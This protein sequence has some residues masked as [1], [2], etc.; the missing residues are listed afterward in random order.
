MSADRSARFQ[1]LL[2]IL[3][4][5]H[6]IMSAAEI[7]EWDQETY[8][9]E[10]ANEARARQVATLRQSAHARFI[11]D[12]TG[13]L[14]EQLSGGDYDPL[15]F[16]GS[17]VR[18]AHRDYLRAR[19]VPASLVGR[20]A[21][22]TSH[23]KV[24][25]RQAREE[26]DW[27]QFAAYLDGILDLCREKIDALGYEECPYDALLDE[28]EPEMRTSQ[29]QQLCE[30]LRP[31]L[32]ELV[33]AIQEAEQPETGFLR[34]RFSLKRQWA[35]GAEV[36]RTIGYDFSRGRQDLSTHPF[37]TAFST[38]DVRI[39]TRLDERWLCSGLFSSL[40]E[41]GHGMYEQG[42]DPDLEGTLL[43]QGTS[44]G[45]HESQSRL[46]ENQIGRSLPFWKYFFPILRRRFN[47]Q[48]NGVELRDFYDAINRVRPSLIR[49]EADEV[50]YNLHIMLRFEIELGLMDG[51]LSVNDVPEVW[52]DRMHTYLGIIPDTD[53]NGCLQDIHWALGAIGYFPTYMLGNLMAAQIFACAAEALPRLESQVG[54]GQFGAL[55]EWLRV[56]VYHWGRRLT[57]SEIMDWVTGGDSISAEPWLAYIR[58]KYSDIYSDLA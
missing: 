14:L 55:L 29:V 47:R 4:P 54:Q 2:K 40:H 23:A 27:P 35:F 24:A 17:L 36:L 45:M 46:W 57:A 53:A 1:E 50:T 9:P 3:Q 22:A 19:K 48:L 33:Y 42:I 38:N 58:T 15:G 43:A 16:R 28:Y 41:A 11:R 25:W 13:E 21:R 51:S 8:M 39:T 37:S 52:N 5:V 34:H 26:N 18:V 30:T 32:L 10:A 12:D 6:D 44:L 56:N 7:L 31:G 20:L 49:V